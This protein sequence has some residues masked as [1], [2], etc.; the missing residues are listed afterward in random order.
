MSPSL[1]L[2]GQMKLYSLAAAAAGVSVLALVA[3]AAAEVV[4]SKAH[5]SVSGGGA[6]NVDLNHDGIPDFG[7]AIFSYQDFS[8][9]FRATFSISPFHGGAVIAGPGTSRQYASALVRGAKIGPSD[10]FAATSGA[11]IERSYGDHVTG[12]TTFRTLKGNWGN[13]PQNRYLGLRFLINGE[14][15]YGWIRLMVTS[16]GAFTL[17]GTITGYAYE[18]VPNKPI[19]AGTAEKPSVGVQ[20]HSAEQVGSPSLGILALGAEGLPLWRREN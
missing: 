16:S 2:N 13:N 7:F 11:V 9:A 4:V 14:T 5:L 17:R 3:P 1:N 19:L 10:R 6:V 12:H 8:P 18:T 15:H 20:I